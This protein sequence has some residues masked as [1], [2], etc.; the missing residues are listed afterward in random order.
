MPVFYFN[1]I[2]IKSDESLKIEFQFN[3]SDSISLNDKVHSAL[4]FN[5]YMSALEP[6][7]VEGSEEYQLVF[8]FTKLWCL[9]EVYIN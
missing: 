2:D 3:N 5:D 7:M 6:L 8:Q 9:K 4:T 1:V